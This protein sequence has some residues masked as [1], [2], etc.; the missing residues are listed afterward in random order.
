MTLLHLST[1]NL[2]AKLFSL[3]DKKVYLPVFHVVVK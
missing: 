3:D 1:T 2:K